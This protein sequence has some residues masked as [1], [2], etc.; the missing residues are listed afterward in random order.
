HL[1]EHNNQTLAML[2][3][4]RSEGRPI[5]YVSLALTAGFFVLMFSSFVPTRQLGFLSG[6]VMLLAMVAELVLTPLLMHS[7]R[8]VTR[9]NVLQVKM[10]RDVVREAPLLRGLSRWEARKLVLLGGLRTLRPG[11]YLVRKGET[12]NELY[13]V[14][15]GR[16]RAFDV[17][18]EGH[19]VTLRE[20]G[21]T[22]IIGEVAVL[23][24]GFRSA[25]VVAEEE[26]EVLALSDAAL[27][28]IRRRFPFTAAK[29][30]R[31]IA[32]VLSERLRDQTAARMTARA[33]ELGVSPPMG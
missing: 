10:R 5:I 32:R 33:V 4:L 8:L 28:R 20:M 1:N 26:C 11:E 3:T 2:Q 31:N 24:D 19:E 22:A 17:D 7:T 16:L 12:G 25:S 9:W 13:M 21:S 29:L 6:L 23:G 30:Y 18:R 14:V 27:E 15:S